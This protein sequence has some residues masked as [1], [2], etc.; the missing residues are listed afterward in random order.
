[1][2]VTDALRGAAASGGME[3]TRIQEYGNS[4]D[5]IAASVR[6]ISDYDDRRAALLQQRKELEGREDEGSRRALARLEI[7]ETIGPVPFDALLVA[8]SGPELIN[9]A[10]QLG[11]Y[12]IDTKRTRILGMSDWI[13]EDTGREPSLVGAWFATPP[14]RAAEDFAVKFRNMYEAPPPAIAAS[15]YDLVALAAILGSQEG[16]P[17][18][19]RETLTSETGF[20]GVGGLFRLRDN[21]LS[22]RSLEVREVRQRGSRVID[23]ARESFENLTN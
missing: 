11:N 8:A 21:G 14:V 5:E 1:L 3:V 4:P 22:E 16:G 12:D 2:R 13:A 10:A 23:K 9:A 17:R 6:T 7:L 15:A 18:F 20:A 19:D